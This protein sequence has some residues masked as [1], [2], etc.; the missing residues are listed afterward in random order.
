MEAGAVENTTVIDFNDYTILSCAGSQDANPTQYEIL[1]AGATLHLW[2]NN[3]KAIELPYKATPNTVI[4]FDFMSD[5]AEGEIN[6][7]GLDE[8]LSLSS[9]RLFQVWGDADLG[10]PGV[11]GLSG[12]RVEALR[13]CC[14]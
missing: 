8:D 7:V 4:E 1:E 10:Y 2:G 9:G 12:Q 13:D 5:G 14:G 6:G 3:W 11:S